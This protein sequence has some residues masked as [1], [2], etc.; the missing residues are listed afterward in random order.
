MH[1]T[2]FENKRYDAAFSRCINTMK[3][4]IEKYGPG[5]LKEWDLVINIEYVICGI[6][7]DREEY[8]DYAKKDRLK[9]LCKKL[10]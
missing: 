3:E 5:L 9:C 8:I 10:A 1:K 2:Y 4:L 6:C 7:I